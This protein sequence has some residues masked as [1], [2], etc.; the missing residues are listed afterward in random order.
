MARPVDPELRD[1][2]LR[3]ATIT[4]A[5]QG[6]AATTMTAVGQAAGVTK[7]GVYFHFRSKEE[8]FFAVLDHW[9]GASRRALDAAAQAAAGGSGAALLRAALAG[10]LSFPFAEPAVA[11]LL[12]VL[13]SEL[14][15]RF[16][17]A[18]REDAREE[19]RALRARLRET[20]ILGSRDGS[21]FAG[22]PVQASLLL[23]AGVHGVVDQWLAAPG[24]VDPF[25]DPEGLA[26]AL[27]APYATGR[28]AGRTEDDEPGAAGREF[29]PLL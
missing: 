2:L 24:D 6:F 27:V 5:A 18:I 8:L 15:G 17:A 19:H 23:A 25:L 22:D 11:R 9:R 4:F 14:H 28:T 26:E 20:L 7:G 12:R 1:R 16:T 10:Y 29:R 13:G 21:L 3:A